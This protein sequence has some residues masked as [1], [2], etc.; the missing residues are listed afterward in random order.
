MK[1]KVEVI[2]NESRGFYSFDLDDMNATQEE[3]EE[4]EDAEKEARI[5]E[6]INSLPEQPYWYLDRFKEI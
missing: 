1:I 5:Q 2:P 3:W 6:A 4:M